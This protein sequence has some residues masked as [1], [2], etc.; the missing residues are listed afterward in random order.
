MEKNKILKIT[1]ILILSI[2]LL[3][4]ATQ[5]KSADVYKTI[6]EKNKRLVYMYRE[7]EGVTFKAGY[8]PQTYQPV[9]GDRI[10]I[11]ITNY[12]LKDGF[13][14]YVGAGN[15]EVPIGNMT[16]DFASGEAE[17]IVNDELYFNGIPLWYHSNTPFKRFIK[18]YVVVPTADAFWNAFQDKMNKYQVPW[19][20][21]GTGY[22]YNFT[23]KDGRGVYFGLTRNYKLIDVS[24]FG[25]EGNITVINFKLNAVY[26]K[27]TGVLL[28]LRVDYL[29][30]ANNTFPFARSPTRYYLKLISSDIEALTGVPTDI[31]SNTGEELVTPIV[32]TAIIIVIGT[33][34]IGEIIELRRPKIEL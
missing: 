33:L 11:T 34:I 25:K 30:G 26:D 19:Q 28:E 13:M 17:Y 18:L 4:P 15:Q 31:P 5:V 20:E 23:I 16:L 7:A 14:W 6:G 22:D 27:R 12:T 3:A 1:A 2:M 24:I 10:I 8:P 29:S 32:T 21:E 9:L